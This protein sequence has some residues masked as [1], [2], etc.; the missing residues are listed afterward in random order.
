MSEQ[1]SADSRGLQYR[2]VSVAFRV[3]S[4][5]AAGRGRGER[6]RGEPDWREVVHSVSLSVPRGR[7]VALVGESG[8]GK[9]VLA[10]SALGLL[11]TTARVSGSIMLDGV[12][13]VGAPAEELRS[14]RGSAIGSIFQEPMTAFDPLFRVGNQIA[15][16]ITAHRSVPD[17]R[18]AVL[19]LL[20]AVGL[21]DVERIYASYPHQLSGGQLQRC[22]IAMAI[23][24]NP[25]VLIA[26]EPTTALDVTVQAGILDLLRVTRERTDSGI[27]LITHDMGVVADIADEVVVLRDGSV[28]ERAPVAELFARPQHEYT[29][30]LLAAVPSLG[31]SRPGSEGSGSGRERE[32]TGSRETSG[33]TVISLR[34]VAVIYPGKSEPAVSDITLSIRAGE[35]LGLVGESGSGKSTIARAVT[36]LI[37]VSHGSITLA[38]VTLCRSEPGGGMWFAPRSEVRKAQSE[39]GI[40][41]QDPASSLNPKRTIAEAIAEPLKVHTDLG[42]AA[43]L[44][45]ANELLDAVKLSGLGSRYPNQLSGG[46]RQRVAIA[47]AIALDPK[48][49]VADEPTSALDV[50]VQAGII[51][52]LRELQERIGFGCLFISH[53]LAVI[54]QVANE[55]AVLHKGRIIEHGPTADVLGNPRDPYTQRLLA[56][57][58]V[59]DPALQAE[60]RAARPSTV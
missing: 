57:V 1:P 6:G 7:V 5:A 29:K 10:M 38:G 25:D 46:Q 19:D 13:L 3:R 40:V 11:P 44:K 43:R 33:D 56:A 12:E 17:V 31:G 21:R 32:A 60:R 20:R 47:R 26:D 37:P 15:E 28:L 23:S 50:S 4:G 30:M 52:L 59:A 42:R 58:P 8:S 24:N 36:G 41:F 45:R 34:D 49:L 16:A 55:V 22:M 18:G 27:L 14:L 53:D 51:E 35:T 48:V 9:S 2:D 39:L 54:E